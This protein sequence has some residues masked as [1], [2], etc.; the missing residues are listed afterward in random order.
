MRLRSST[1]V[2]SG[3]LG[4]HVACTQTSAAPSS[5]GGTDGGDQDVVSSGQVPDAG[6][7]ATD[8]TDDAD[9]DASDAADRDEFY[10]AGSGVYGTFGPACIASFSCDGGLCLFPVDGGCAAKGAC[11][12][13]AP[14]P[15]V[16]E[17]AHA[18]AMCACDGTATYQ[19]DCMALGYAEAPVPSPTSLVCPADDGSDAGGDG[20]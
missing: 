13:N 10:D 20:G 11:F 15:G 4:F 19:L 6:S 3:L 12:Y 16:A 7:D 18:T 9:G 2:L 1:L 14:P 17:C 8:A 5:E